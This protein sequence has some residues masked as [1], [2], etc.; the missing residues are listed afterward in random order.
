MAK[1]KFVTSR[2][3]A[4][5]GFQLNDGR[6]IAILDKDGQFLIKFDTPFNLETGE[7]GEQPPYKPFGTNSLPDGFTDLNTL[8]REKKGK[9][10]HCYDEFDVDLGWVRTMSVRRIKKIQKTFAQHGFNVSEKAI[11]HNYNAWMGDMKSGYRD[12]ENG[13]HLFTPCGC[14]PLSFR[15]TTLNQ[16]CDDWQTTYTC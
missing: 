5:W 11:L 14:N 9:E 4:Q 1:I 12:E 6:I 13:N 15:A 16:M 10:V 3:E 2:F 7:I 8:I